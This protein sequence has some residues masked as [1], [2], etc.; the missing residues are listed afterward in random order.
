MI[1]IYKKGANEKLSEN[2]NTTEFDCKCTK[3]NTTQIDP[4][5]IA[6]LQ[7]IRDNFNAPVTINSGFRCKEHNTSVGGSKNSQHL[8]GS[9]ADIAVKGVDPINV[10]RYA[11]QIGVKGIGLYQWGCH[12][13]TRIKKSFWYSSAELSRETFF[14][15]AAK[16]KAFQNAAIKDGFT[17][18]SGADGIWGKEC[19]NVAK[20]AILKKRIVYKYKNLTAFVQA[21]LGVESDGKF[22]SNT[23]D[24]VIQYQLKNALS[25]DGKVGINTYKKLLGVA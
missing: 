9:A 6:F 16:I 12:I 1:N 22:G 11:E 5:L 3:C 4:L 2:F 20:N 18:P 14:N 17:L 7:K 8:T 15:T 19:E 21:A 10:A 13:D 23:R 25:P 24:A